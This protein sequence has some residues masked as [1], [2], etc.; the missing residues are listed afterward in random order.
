MPDGPH[1]YLLAITVDSDARLRA[2]VAGCLKCLDKRAGISTGPLLR[3]PDGVTVAELLGA[4]AEVE[5]LR[6]AIATHRAQ[7]A[8]D[9]CIEDDDRLYAALHDGVP[10]DRRVGSKDAM[11][12]N[13]ARFIERRCEGGGWPSYVDL[14]AEVVRLRGIIEG[15]AARIH[16]QS[17]LLSKRAEKGD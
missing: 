1:T 7:K 12:A 4:V 10:C 17:E 16:A 15:F 9:R 5:R 13:C 11:L 8:D 14:E 6:E 2:G 3:L